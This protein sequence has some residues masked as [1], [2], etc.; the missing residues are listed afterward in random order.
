MRPSIAPPT[1]VAEI[2]AAALELFATRGFRATT[3]HDIGAAVGIRGPSIYKHVP[4]KQVLLSTLMTTTMD[5][6]LAAQTVALHSATE[7]AGQ[8]RQMVH[9]HVHYHALHRYETFVGNRELDN[10]DEPV[11]ARLLQQRARYECN[12]RGVLSDG[13]A[14]G[15]FRILSAQL[16]S[17]AILD[18]GVGVSSWFDPSGQYSADELADLYSTMALRMLG[19]DPAG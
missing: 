17:Y 12:L 15:V 6:L 19:T 8:V 11:R 7:H 1:R 10:L 4:S 9:A 3:M 2:H 13:V 18:M 16:A 5:R 14:A